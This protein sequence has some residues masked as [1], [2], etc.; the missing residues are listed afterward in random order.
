M[1]ILLQNMDSSKVI[2]S[3]DT[4]NYTIPASGMYV[5]DVQMSELPPS[6][7]SIVIKQNSV[8]KAASSAPAAAQQILDLRI[9]LNCSANDV[10]SIEI[11]SALA[12]E[13]APNVIKGII[14][15][16]PGSF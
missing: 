5:I 11:T 1:S 9:V 7:L 12:A 15:I 3:L 13:A 8:S 4:Y 2:S 6:Q 10:I 14:N 16:H